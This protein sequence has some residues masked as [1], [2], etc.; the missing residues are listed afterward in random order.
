MAF[1]NFTMPVVTELR[2]LIEDRLS[3]APAS[4]YRYPLGYCTWGADEIMAALECL[5]TQQTTMWAKTEEFER[6]FSEYLRSTDSIMVNSG[7]SADLVMMLAARESGLLKPGDEILIPAVTWPTQVWA[8]VQ[9]GFSVKLIDVDPQTLNTS[10]EIIE[11]AITSKTKALFLVHLMGNPCEMDRIQEIA[12]KHKLLIF[13]DCCEAL[14]A[15]Y[16]GKKV[17]TFGIASAFSFFA[18]HH[19]STLEGGMIFSSYPN[20]L[21]TCRLMRA[22]G[23]A[24]DLRGRAFDVD[25]F[26]RYGCVED[27]RYL[28]LG[29]GF[30]FR[31]TELNAAFGLIQL[32]K[33]DTLNANRNHNFERVH[34]GFRATNGHTV[35]QLMVTNYK[36]KPAW[37]ALPFVLR[38]G[39]PYSRKNVTEYLQSFGVDTRPIVGGNVARHPAFWKYPEMVSGALPGADEIHG[40]G[41]YLGLSPVEDSMDEIVGLLNGMDSNLRDRY[42][43]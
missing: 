8:A 5:L 33:L 7:S 43:A 38:E 11:A 13:E 1:D 17:G 28:F 36:A 25:V 15:S 19:I 41:F 30:N 39:L 29:M 32:G 34:T 35:Q 37:F 3:H 27:D 10:P 31:P 40:R 26:R 16:D 9:A 18:S 24:R 23:W 4:P 20:F 22:H 42:V 21:D 12:Q 14:G 6:E 2:S